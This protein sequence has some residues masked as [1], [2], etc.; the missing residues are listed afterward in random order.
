[1]NKSKEEK[2]IK[3]WK[4]YC[5]GDIRDETIESIADWWLSKFASHQLEMEKKLKAR[6]YLHTHNSIPCYTDEADE[7][8]RKC[9]E[10][11][12]IDDTLSILRG[13]N[14]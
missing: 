4:S 8:C 14:K 3:E 5:L 2:L 12:V 11:K 9:I 13:E 7:G 1:M 6:E 10:N